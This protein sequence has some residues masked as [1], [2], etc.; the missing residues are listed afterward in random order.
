MTQF[1]IV[2]HLNKE[3]SKSG[4]LGETVQRIWGVASLADHKK[5]ISRDGT[6]SNINKSL[7]LFVFFFIL[8]LTSLKSSLKARQGEY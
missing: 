6:F 7:L 3:D 2:F 8:K 5:Y 1:F 4:P